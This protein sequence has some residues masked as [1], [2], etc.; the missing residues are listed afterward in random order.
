MAISAKAFE[1]VDETMPI[2]V[3]LVQEIVDTLTF[4]G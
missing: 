2:V 4:T 1:D 3:T